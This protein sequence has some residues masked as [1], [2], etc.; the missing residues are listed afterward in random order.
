METHSHMEC[1]DKFDF[2]P[3]FLGLSCLG[4]IITLLV[5]FALPQLRNLPG[6]IVMNLTLSLLIAFVVLLME[7]LI[8]QPQNI[9]RALCMALGIY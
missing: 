9:Q 8:I 1:K 2:Y 7:Q 5:Y 3:Y 4:L 6:K